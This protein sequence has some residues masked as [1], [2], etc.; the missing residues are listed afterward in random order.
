[1][2]RLEEARVGICSG[3]QQG[4]RRAHEAVRVTES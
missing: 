1:M 4:L 2:R 3:V